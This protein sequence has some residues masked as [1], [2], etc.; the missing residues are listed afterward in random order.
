MG[1]LPL[2]LRASPLEKQRGSEEL[3]NAAQNDA[4]CLIGHLFQADRN[5]TCRVAR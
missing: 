2:L 3:F 1:E 4:I 5:G